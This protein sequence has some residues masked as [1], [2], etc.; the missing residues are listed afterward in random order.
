MNPNNKLRAALR[1]AL[2]FAGTYLLLAIASAARWLQRHFGTVDIDQFLFHL[3]Q[4]S[5]GLLSGDTTLVRSA[6]RNI[7]AA[8]VAYAALAIALA[9]ALGRWRRTAPAVRRLL[10]LW[11]HPLGQAGAFCLVTAWAGLSTLAWH[12]QDLERRDWI[13]ELHR[14]PERLVAPARKPNLLLVYAESLEATYDTPAFPERLLAPLELPGFGGHSVSFGDFQQAA[15]TGWTI[16]GIV[17]SQCGLP[18]KPLGFM[19]H[20]D[21]GEAAP[22]FLPGADCLGD[23]LARHGWHNVF[24]NGGSLAFAGKGRFLWNHGYHAAF[25]LEDWQQLAPNAHTN[26]WGLDDD[27]LFT[28]A[29]G[30]LRALVA[31]GKPF[32]LTLLT[33][34]MHPPRGFLAPSCPGVHGDMRDAVA[35]TAR[36]LAGFLE[37]ARREGLLRDTLVVVMGDH[38]GMHSELSPRLQQARHR[39]IYNRMLNAPALA[40]NRDAINHFDMLPTVL[41]ALGFDL[42]G[43]R[44]ALGC[45]AL[46][47]VDCQS[48]TQDLQADAK[49]RM[50]SAFYEALWGL[51]DGRGAA[52]AIHP[53]P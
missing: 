22:A 36:L 49:L 30:Q 44:F 12:P 11:R 15:G 21:L 6:L 10:A 9:W 38:L 43:G 25:G 17:A 51:P 13:A 7:V 24:L 42:G 39:R 35:C 16:A 45:A 2:L 18:L 20:N 37:D 52:V 26:A 47:P 23:V 53:E 27:D 34:G 41:T 31:A 48:L 50:R 19:G 8:P 4:R 14:P 1:A 33:V 32:N 46:G 40:P 3:Q 28:Q 5:A 29:L